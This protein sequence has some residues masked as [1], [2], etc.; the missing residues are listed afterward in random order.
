MYVKLTIYAFQRSYQTIRSHL[1]GECH[2]CLNVRCLNHANICRKVS[3]QTE[4]YLKYL[5]C[6]L[7]F[8]AKISFTPLLHH[9]GGCRGCP[10][11][12]TSSRNYNLLVWSAVFQPKRNDIKKTYK[13]YQNPVKSY[14]F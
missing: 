10:E 12:Q 1:L 14:C 11:K 3:K 13:N 8:L 2:I 7:G 4:V 6:T 5:G 9:P